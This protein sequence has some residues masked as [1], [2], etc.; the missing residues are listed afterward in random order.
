M[1]GKAEVI[2]GRVEEA[3][4][5]LTNNDRLRNK[6]KADQATGK[7]KQVASARKALDKAKNTAE[8]CATK[9]D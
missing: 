4:G 2:K 8:S 1:S 9:C 3:A 5:A 7:A 6:G